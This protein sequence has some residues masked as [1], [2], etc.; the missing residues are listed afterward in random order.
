[1]YQRVTVSVFD[2]VPSQTCQKKKRTYYLYAGRK[3]PNNFHTIHQFLPGPPIFKTAG[4]NSYVNP[5]I[6]QLGCQGQGLFFCSANKGKKIA[7]GKENIHALFLYD[8]RED[9]QE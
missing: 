5:S 8:F 2:K 6:D 9:K 1:M 4:Y 3:Q 7:D